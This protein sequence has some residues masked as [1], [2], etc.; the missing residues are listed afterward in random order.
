MKPTRS[1][2]PPSVIDLSRR[3][4]WER[5]LLRSRGIALGRLLRIAFN[6]DAIYEAAERLLKTLRKSG[7]FEVEYEGS[8]PFARCSAVAS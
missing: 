8:I 2:H 4:S 3:R 1:G 7:N 5:Q 6:I